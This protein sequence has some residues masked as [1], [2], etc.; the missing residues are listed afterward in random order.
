M[1]LFHHR[2]TAQTALSAL[3]LAAAI[4]GLLMSHAS[5]AV[6]GSEVTAASKGWTV[7]LWVARTTTRAGTTIPATITLDNRTGHRVEVTGCPGV[8]FTIVAS[9]ANVPNRPVIAAEYCGSAMTPGI[10]VFHTKVLTDYQTC[11]IKD[12]PRCGSPRKLPALPAG[13]YHTY[14]IWPTAM[15]TLPRPASVAI[16]LRP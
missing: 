15:P 3:A 14:V 4:C 13:T 11:G 5:A 7:E 8:I 2:Q 16:T 6:N 1:K 9:N 12:S 10:H